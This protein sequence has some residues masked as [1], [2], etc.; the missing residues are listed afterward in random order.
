VRVRREQ[1][2]GDLVQQALSDSTDSAGAFRRNSDH[3][4]SPSSCS[5]FTC[6]KSVIISGGKGCGSS[7][8]A[9]FRTSRTLRNHKVFDCH[10]AQIV[11]ITHACTGSFNDTLSDDLVYW[12]IAVADMESL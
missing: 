4:C 8:R 1:V 2:R 5:A 12:I 10:L 3:Y 11:R 6:I 7:E 9:R